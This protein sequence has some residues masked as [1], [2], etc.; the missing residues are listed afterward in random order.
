MNV[1]EEAKLRANGKPASIQYQIGKKPTTEFYNFAALDDK[2]GVTISKNASPVE[3]VMSA[4]KAR[5][6]A[7]WLER[8]ASW[9]EGI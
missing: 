6:L 3:F 1:K 8:Y 5:N 2:S 9:V 7:A 4:K